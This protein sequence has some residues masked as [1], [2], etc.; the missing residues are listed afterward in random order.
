MKRACT[1]CKLNNI[2]ADKVLKEWLNAQKKKSVE[3]N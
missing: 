3:Q 1:D 2:E